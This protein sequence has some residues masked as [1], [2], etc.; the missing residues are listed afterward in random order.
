M[1]D[2]IKIHDLYFRPYL[3]AAD[4]RKRVEAMGHEL[5]A[6][7]ADKKPVFLGV[8]N[9]AFVFAADLLRACPFECELSFIKLSSY[10]GT[11]ST[12]DVVT[13]IGLEADL[14]GRHV[15]L[16]EDIIDSG[17]TMHRFLPE[18]QALKPASVAIAAL[19]VKPEALE[20]QIRVDFRGFDI[21]QKFVVGYGLDYDGLGRNLEDIYEV[22]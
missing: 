14:A 9:G 7:Y 12:G 8:L 19:L 20:Y 4:I 18:L 17:L 16:V 3:S 15:V 22:S 13:R 21:P 5:N 1:M 2:S 11:A 6:V 10:S